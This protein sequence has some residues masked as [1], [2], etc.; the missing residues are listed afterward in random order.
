[1][2]IS[3]LHATA[4]PEEAKKCQKLWLDRADNRANIEI[5]TCVDADDEACKEAFPNAAISPQ[6]TAC[7][8]WNKAA[9]Y[10]TGDVLVVL[11]DDWICPAGWDGIIESYM[12][13]GADIL[14]VGDKHRKDDL[15]CHPIVSK[16]FY[17]TVGY[18]WHPSFKSVYCDNWFTTMAKSWGYVDATESGTIDLG[19]VHAN[20]SQGY[21]AEDEVAKISNSKERYTHGEDAMKRLV[22]N[23]VVLAFTAYN[24]VDYLKQTLDS[25]L[26]TNLEL[27]TSVQFYIEPS[28]KLDEIT[29]V[30]DDFAS[31]CPT[32]VIKHVNPE[33][34]GVLKNPWKLFENL[35]DK[36]LASFV[37]LGEDDFIVSPDTLDFIEATRKQVNDRTLAVCAKWVGKDS[38]ANPETWHR[39]QEF[40]GNIWGMTKWSWT[41]FLK[42]GWDMDYSSGAPDGTPSGWDWNIGLRVI[43]N[44]NLHCIVPTA[45]RSYHIGTVGVHCTEEDY[46]NTT[47]HNFVRDIYVG[48]YSEKQPKVQVKAPVIEEALHTY[49]STGDAGD[50]FVSLATIK[51]L[52]GKTTLYLRDGGG[53]SGIVSRA[54]LVKP[55]IEAQPYIKAVEI[56]KDEPIEW[57]SEG[58]R[59]G[60]VDRIA[61]LADCHAKHALHVGFI[62]SLPDMSK[63]WLTVDP[64]MSYAGRIICNRSPRY[65]NPFFPWRKIVEH[66]GSRLIFIGM[67]HEHH[68]FCETFGGVEY[69]LTK[70]FLEVAQM[71]AGSSLYIGN[72]SACMTIAE[73]LKHP[74]ILEGSLVIPDCVY[75][76]AGNAQYV[77]DGSVK[78]PD[79]EGS[80]ELVIPSQALRWQDFDINIVPKVG[81]NWGWHY[82]FGDTMIVESIVAVAVKRL[83][84]LSGWEMEKCKEEVV[85]YTVNAAPGFFASRVNFSQFD[86][87]KRALLAAG[88]KDHPLLSVG[89]GKFQL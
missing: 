83:K 37:I 69:K 39:S 31:K 24:R 22:G 20:P 56:W 17:D 50:C 40:T 78:L 5:I 29:K 44:N 38:D 76:Q 42:D 8:A 52:G 67:P 6:K 62:K 3:L 87:C 81:M 26:K 82:K 1:M 11:D 68:A 46:K 79:I 27:V 21:G 54:H 13:N 14:H 32:P 70:D 61:N 60:W 30:I 36:Q 23:N 57:A 48:K 10:A 7:A 64:D 53:A 15:I 86:T 4:R 75:P 12:C 28:D 34:Y 35:F 72:Q 84:R 58:F 80:G 49:S 88:L 25:W 18:I 89:V 74:R 66:Y 55:L 71:I 33:K 47:T 19:W 51:H 41:R 85:R 65:N 16:Q 2:K 9:E 59:G 77:F 45:S 43:P 73:G 63:P